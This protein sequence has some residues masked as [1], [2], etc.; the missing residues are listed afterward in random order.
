MRLSNFDTYTVFNYI[1]DTP[2]YKLYNIN[3]LTYPPTFFHFTTTNT[4]LT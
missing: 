3:D 2:N 4:N 1:I